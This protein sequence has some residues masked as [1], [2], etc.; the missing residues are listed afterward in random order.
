V[1]K[2]WWMLLAPA[3]HDDEGWMWVPG[4]LMKGL[5]QHFQVVR[6]EEEKAQVAMKN[7]KKNWGTG[8][9]RTAWLRA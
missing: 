1:Q 7:L 8:G 5:H 3:R 4:A 9:N 6:H 2:T